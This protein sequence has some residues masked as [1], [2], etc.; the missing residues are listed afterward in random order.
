MFKCKAF[1]P[2]AKVLD[3]L[4]ELYLLQWMDKI[5]QKPLLDFFTRAD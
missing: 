2:V 4:V 3:M 1:S 5:A